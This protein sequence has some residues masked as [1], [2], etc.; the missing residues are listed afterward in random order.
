LK[1]EETI[2]S[3]FLWADSDFVFLENELPRGPGPDL[4][5][6]RGRPDGGAAALRHLQEDPAGAAH[7]GVILRRTATPLPPDIVS[8]AFPKRIYDMVDSRRTLADITLETHA[9]EYNVCQVLYVMVQKGYLE[10]GKARRRRRR[11]TRRTARRLSW[12]RRRS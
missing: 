2:Y 8:K 4:H 6:S 1:A 5:P 9:S 12:R 3:L 11:V 7:N 10:V